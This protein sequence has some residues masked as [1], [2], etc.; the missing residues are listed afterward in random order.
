M[1]KYAIICFQSAKNARGYQ[2]PYEKTGI[3][4]NEPPGV[5]P[6]VNTTTVGIIGKKEPAYDGY[7]AYIMNSN[8]VE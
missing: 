8:P 2:V 6:S 7:H 1:K 5:V 3:S 4:K